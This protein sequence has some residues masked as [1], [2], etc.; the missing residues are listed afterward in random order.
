MEIW[1]IIIA[2][3]GG[4][5]SI[6]SMVMYFVNKW[7][8]AGTELERMRLQKAILEFEIIKKKEN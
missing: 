4:L 7:V 3:S 5:F 1:K 8:K 2:V 6:T